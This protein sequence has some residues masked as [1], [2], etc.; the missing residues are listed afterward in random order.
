MRW[1]NN[2][3]DLPELCFK[4]IF[5]NEQFSYKGMWQ[6]KTTTSQKKLKCVH[7]GDFLYIEQNPRTGSDSARKARGGSEIMWII[8]KPTGKYV[9]RVTQNGGVIVAKWL[10]GQNNVRKWYATKGRN[11]KVNG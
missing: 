1:T 9:C 10:P 3:Q 7:I 11:K 2:P 8:H 4:A 5:R 6:A